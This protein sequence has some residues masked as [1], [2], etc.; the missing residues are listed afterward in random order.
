MV[1]QIYVEKL[2]PKIVT[3]PYPL[4]FI[5]GLAQT[6]TNFLSTPD[7]RPGWASFFLSQG[8][9]V[10]LSDQSSRGRSAWHPS[11]GSMGAVS[12]ETIE[13]IFTATQ[14]YNLWPQAAL[15]TQWPGTGKIGDSTFDAFYSSQ[16]QFQ[17]DDFI[18]EAQ[19][20][21]AYTALLDKIGPSHVVTHSQA[22]VIGWRMGDLRPALVKSIVAIEPAGP[23]FINYYLFAGPRRDYGLT[24]HEI[25]YE[26]SAGPN[27]SLLTTVTIPSESANRTD[28]I[29]QAE[30]AKQLKILAQIAT[31]VVT[32]EA[33]FHATHDFCTVEYL[34][35]A[36]VGVEHLQLKTEEIHGNGHMMF[37][38]KNNVEIAE[39]IHRWLE[40]QEK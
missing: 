16:V 9:V 4:I 28:C 40:Q 2:T 12:A 32:G 5:A 36:G 34:R 11:I 8:Y 3:Q 35:Q 37:M 21:H 26:P 23:P 33:S 1:G 30:P 25:E 10:Y 29:L 19:N 31:L 22:G 27:G 6:G 18:T 14:D 38:E 39:R 17:T 20:A 24:Y 7:N 13:Q 15:H